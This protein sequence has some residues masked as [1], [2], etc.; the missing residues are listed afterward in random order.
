MVEYCADSGSLV[1]RICGHDR[2]CLSLDAGVWGLAMMNDFDH[3][4]DYPLDVHARLAVALARIEELEQCEEGERAY[5][6]RIATEGCQDKN[7]VALTE[8]LSARNVELERFERHRLHLY[9]LCESMLDALGID[10]SELPPPRSDHIIKECSNLRAEHDRL[11]D[12]VARLREVVLEWEER[13]AAC[14]PENV[15]FEEVI[16]KLRALV[17]L[18]RDVILGGGALRMAKREYL[19]EAADWDKA[20]C[21]AIGITAEHKAIEENP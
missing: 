12:E 7:L 20:L 13:E 10:Q 18:T 9:E 21:D 1:G 6:V 3:P 14:C 17:D 5:A 15:P 16:E 11:A 19:D 2:R 4:T 8:V